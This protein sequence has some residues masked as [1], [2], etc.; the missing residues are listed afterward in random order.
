MNGLDITQTGSGFNYISLNE[1]QTTQVHEKKVKFWMQSE[2]G[3]SFDFTIKFKLNRNIS[4]GSG[5][6]RATYN[7]PFAI[8]K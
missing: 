5:R 8:R 6:R 1:L 4:S 7:P 2:D 3:R